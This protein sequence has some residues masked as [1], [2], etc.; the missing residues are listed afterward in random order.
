[1]PIS[2]S[3][4]AAGDDWSD[5]QV[6]ATPLFVAESDV[7]RQNGYYMLNNIPIPLFVMGL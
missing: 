3:E 6:V 4:C 1:M 2:V 7:F 5:H